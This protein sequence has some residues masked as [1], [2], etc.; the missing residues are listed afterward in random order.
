MIYPFHYQLEQRQALEA[1]HVCLPLAS[2]LSFNTPY[3]GY[4]LEGRLSAVRRLS[5]PKPP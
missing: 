5:Q 4:S 3:G 2:L 1:S